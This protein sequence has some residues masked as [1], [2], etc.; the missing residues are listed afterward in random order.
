MKKFLL[1]FL[2]LLSTVPAF[3][4]N[5][6]ITVVAPNGGENWIIGCPATIQWVTTTTVL[7]PV[8]I[9]LYKNGAF[10]M[11]IVPSVPAGTSTFTWIPPY[12]VAPGNTFKVKVTVITSSVV[13]GI[14]DFSNNNFSINLG[15]ITVTSP[16]GGEIWQYGTT[17]LI[18]WTDNLC[19]NV[20]IE[21]WKGGSFYSL[22]ASSV[23]SNGTFPWAITNAIA[24]GTDYKVK[25]LG[26]GVNSSTANIV[27][28]FSNANFTIGSGCMITVTS[29]NGGEAWAKGSTHVI[30]WQSN[31]T[32]NLRIE[33]WR[34]G[35]YN[36][37]I[38]ASV[39]NSGSCPWAIP[40][41]L[42][43]G[44]DYK[45]KIMA[46]SNTGTTSCFD[47]SDNNFS[48]LGTNI[49]P[50]SHLMPVNVS[51]YPNP[52]SSTLNVRFDEIPSGQ[53]TLQVI[54]VTGKIMQEEVFGSVNGTG[55][56]EMNTSDLASSPYVL[57]VRGVNG[58]IAR[59]TFVVLR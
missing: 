19:D 12:S 32:Y 43:A 27:Y 25:I 59:A 58:V 16:N 56:L 7:A 4:Q 51:L 50:Q 2:V 47:F 49:T 35:V 17:H 15:T 41:T 11:T 1:S 31:I 5:S 36:S 48:I 46:L 57:V 26:L 14:Y 44:N 6:G 39:P 8:K 30:T 20:R 9:E 29:P 45:V 34:G 42:P 22:L 52:V 18:T 21:L 33:L 54:S 13:P 55:I 38:A 23:P 37:V 28:D 53:V 40:T 3:S 24:P 10:Y